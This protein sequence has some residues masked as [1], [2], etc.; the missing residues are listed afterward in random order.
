MLK[1]IL[2]SLIFVLAVGQAF[3]QVT[4]SSISGNVKAQGDA[5]LI[6]ATI[7]ATHLPSG[8]VYSTISQ[9]GGTFSIQNMRSG[10]PYRIEISYVG[11]QQKVIEDATLILGEAFQVNE[12]LGA[13]GQQLQEVT[14]VSNRQNPILN[15]QRTGASTNINARQLG[16]LPTISRSITD[17]T[18]LTPQANGT[19]FAGRDG[20]LNS[21]KI[22]GA[23]LNN[24]FGLSSDLLPG[25]DAQPISLDAIQEVQV[26]VAPYDVRQSGF[27][28]AGINAVTRSGTNQ[29]SGSAYGL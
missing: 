11:Y 9:N 6:G 14:I 2:Y 25:G 5:P 13:E 20:R 7:T 18:R 29:F 27:T 10:G 24:A 19:N 22:D 17:F 26:N 16:T 3:A 1:R 8:T 21:V 23:T 12:T 28:G 15:N 4:T